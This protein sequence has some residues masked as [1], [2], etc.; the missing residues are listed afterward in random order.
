[1]KSLFDKNVR[2]ALEFNYRFDL[3]CSNILVNMKGAA[4]FTIEGLV[5]ILKEAF[6]S[7]IDDGTKQARVLAIGKFLG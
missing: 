7:T 6:F 1:M 5:S 3:F 2:Y 4:C